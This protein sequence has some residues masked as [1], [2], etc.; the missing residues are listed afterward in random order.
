MALIDTCPTRTARERADLIIGD[1]EKLIAYIMG[2][3]QQIEGGQH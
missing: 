1:A 2:G 3:Q